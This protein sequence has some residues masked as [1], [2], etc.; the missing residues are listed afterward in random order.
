MEIS[1]LTQINDARRSRKAI[2]V[3]THIV[4]GEQTL[5]SPGSPVA[6]ESGGEL[7]KE[8]ARRFRSGKSGT[9]SIGGEQVFFRVHVPSPRLVVIG[10][11]HISQALVPVAQSCEF[12]VTVIDPRTAFASIDRFPSVNLLAEWPDNV[13]QGQPLDPYTALVALTHDPKVD[14]LPL[15]LA[16]QAQ[17]FYIGALGSRKTHAK[18]M[19]RFAEAGLEES[20]MAAVHAPIGL[21][22]GSAT[23]AEIAVSI[24]AEIIQTLRKEPVA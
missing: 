15:Q 9:V 13:L 20:A 5:I 1:L 8:A 3:A 11:V 2:A 18:R 4:S 16:M 7:G 17:C 10:A 14:D 22:I 21:D 24:V 12:D 6:G 19:A 23:P